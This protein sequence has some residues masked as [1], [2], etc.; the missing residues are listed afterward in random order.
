MEREAA[1]RYADE[2][3]GLGVYMGALDGLAGM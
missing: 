1:G 3:G 2:V